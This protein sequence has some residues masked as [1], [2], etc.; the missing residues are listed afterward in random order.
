[1]KKAIFFDIDGTLLDSANGMNSMTTA[2]KDS[3]RKLQKD[4]NHVFIATGRP[5]AFLTEDILNF[6]FDG[7]VLMNGALV[8]LND[9]SLNNQ[10]DI[11]LTVHKNALFRDAFSKETLNELLH[12]FKE[13]NIEYI[14]QDEKYSYIPKDFKN[15]KAIYDNI[16]I[17][18]KYIK[19]DYDVNNINISKIELIYIDEESLNFCKSLE[20]KGFKYV[21]HKE[22]KLIEIY[23]EKNSKASGILKVLD[24]YDVNIN[25]SY[26]FGDSNND[27]EMLNTVGCGIVMGNASDYIKSLAREITL[28]VSEDGVAYGIDNYILKPV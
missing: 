9:E 1:M 3:I 24:H 20:D 22:F 13:R 21:W 17:S 2:V 25:D 23:S 7:Y 28:P 4:N 8:L 11:S 6:G 15:L 5:Y 19:T 10:D 18:N 14:L 26:A 16:G 27:I 12:E